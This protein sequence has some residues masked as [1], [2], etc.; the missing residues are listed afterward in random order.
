MANPNHIRRWPV[1]IV[2]ALVTI[3]AGCGGRTAPFAKSTHAQGVT[4][5]PPADGYRYAGASQPLQQERRATVASE[6]PPITAAIAP[7][8]AT[9]GVDVASVVGAGATGNKELR[10]AMMRALMQRGVR[11]STK[12]TPPHIRIE[13]QV[14]LGTVQAGSQSAAIE[15]RVKDA[16]GQLIGTVAQ[17]NNIPATTTTVGWGASALG[18]AQAAA[19]EISRLIAAAR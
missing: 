5:T 10:D 12:P 6:Q 16:G 19:P 9:R 13:A 7:T 4:L 8:G 1:Y 3:V 15:W 18:A 14:R 11:L 17:S 2:L